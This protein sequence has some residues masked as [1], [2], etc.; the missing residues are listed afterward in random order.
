MVKMSTIHREEVLSIL[1]KVL[2]NVV[3]VS[4]TPGSLI[5]D[6]VKNNFRFISNIV[7]KDG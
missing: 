4:P 5:R 2:E 1:L 6:T 7:H 3:K